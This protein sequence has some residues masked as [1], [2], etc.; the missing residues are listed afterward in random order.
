[1][2]TSQKQTSETVSTVFPRSVL[3]VN[4]EEFGK[5]EDNPDPQCSPLKLIEKDGKPLPEGLHGHV[6]IISAAGSVDS[7]NSPSTDV[8]FPSADGYTPFYN[9]DGIIYRFDFDNLPEGIFVNTGL[10]KTPCYYADVAT[11][12]I[13]PD[14][15]NL[16]FE[17]RGIMRMSLQLGIRNQLNTGFLPLKFSNGEPDR[18]LVTWDIGRPYE[19]DTKTLELATPVGKNEEWRPLNPLLADLP[20]QPPFPFPLVQ[21]SAHPCFDYKTGEMFNVNSGRSLSTFISQLRPLIYGV[22]DFINIFKKPTD[23]PPITKTPASP[24]N[25]FQGLLETGKRFV[26]WLYNL[27]QFFNIFNNFVDIVCWDGTGNLKK[28]NVTYK[29]CPLRIQQSMHQI[30][31][32]ENYVVLVDTA[33]KFLLEEI[34]PAPSKK[35]YENVEKFLRNWLDRPQ[36]PDTYVYIVSRED[37]KEGRKKV[38]A[39]KV[40]IPRETTHFLTDYSDSGKKIT[41]HMAHVCAW[42][43]AEWIRAIDFDNTD[44]KPLSNK[45]PPMYGMT[46][47]P[48]DISRMGCYV[49]DAENAKVVRSD[50]TSVYQDNSP[51]QQAEKKEFCQY[52]W[53]PA[54]YAYQD[55][56][57]TEKFQDIYWSFFGAWE[58][59]LTEHGLKMYAPYKYREVPVPEL[60]ELTKKGI[61]SNLLRLHIKPLESVK[62]G[63]NRLEIQDIYQFETDYFVNSPQFIPSKTGVD[64]SSTNGYIMCVVYHGTDDQPDNGN[65]IWIFDA[66]NLKQGPL[67]KLWHPQLNFGITVHTT[68]LPKIA[69]RT[70]T[71]NIPVEQDYQDLVAQQPAEI[72]ELFEKEIYPHFKSK[73]L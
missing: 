5:P 30:G 16:I 28:W 54:L 63:E 37:L 11:Q 19:I 24:K 71:Y 43:V 51:G 48:L 50:L 52:T 13:A 27:L 20:L 10:A 32:T 40:V 29:G 65:Q 12:K 3:S 46:V 4:R 45:L 17:N 55:N 61:K 64:G 15:N 53:G 6:F 44:E 41:L 9:G 59:I 72:Q 70:A 25:L 33:F 31:L 66:T 56:Q 42:D 49:I 18:L 73:N 8:V 69:K 58:D 7:K 21:S 47:G 67:C 38:E 35:K 68:W 14:R 1:M 23:T 39:K 26:Q 2:N 57:P 34:L 36:L 22:L 62:D 60:L